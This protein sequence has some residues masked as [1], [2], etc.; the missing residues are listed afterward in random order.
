MLIAIEGC[1]GAGKTTVAKGLASL[2]GST[3]LL[4]DF[5][6]NPFLR[7]FY[8]DPVGN[9]VETEFAFLMLHFHQLKGI[10]QTLASSEVI[11]DFHLGKDV[12]YAELNLGDPR[13]TRLFGELYQLCSERVPAPD[14]LVFLSASTERIVERIRSRNRNF[15]LAIDPEYYGVVNAAYEDLFL[16][17][18]GPK[19]RI[20]MNRWDFVAEPA[21]YEELNVLVDTEISSRE[22]AR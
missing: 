14:L 21:L 9:A 6:V 20:D 7:D 16:Q 8:D 13:F 2:R 1:L 18:S 4:E 19:V 12:L 3:P 22:G 10:S 15:E 5:E 17:Y 11:A